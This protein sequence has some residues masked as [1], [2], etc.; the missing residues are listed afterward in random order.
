M[1][2]DNAPI[3]MTKG[4]EETV[5]YLR[6][7]A[8]AC[9]MVG[10]PLYEHLLD[11]AADDVERGGAVW[12]LLEPFVGRPLSYG[13]PLKL[14]GA[15]H[16][17]VLEGSAPQL[18]ELYPSAGGALDLDRSWPAFEQTLAEHADRLP[19]L[20]ERP[21]QTNEVGR[22]A[23]L[24]GGFLTVARETG[25]PLR[26][27]ELGT[28]AGLNLRW[29]RYLYSAGERRWGD[30]SS[31]VLQLLDPA[32]APLL[33]TDAVVGSRRGCDTHPLD[34]SS[35]EDRLTLMS[36]VW[37]DQTWRFSLLT[38]ALEEAAK[39]PALV[40]QADAADWIENALA[41]RVPNV[42]TI[43]FHSLVLFWM[44]RRERARITGA[45]S[46]AAAEAT[47]HSPFAWLKMEAAGEQADV[48]L[49][50]WPGGEQRTLARAGY[51]GRPVT[52][53]AGS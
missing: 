18:A 51:H 19:S 14:L 48:V 24:L 2:L 42:A 12:P 49:T 17:L 30:P 34:P 35:L 39:A 16:R 47:R 45:I 29:D 50:T 9:A 26:L 53:L 4:Q 27:L 5:R 13:A 32:S 1:S 23:A 22:S 3:S 20:I 44:G 15:V 31:N 46:A 37:P 28:S 41:E 11:A 21:V 43:V 10:S 38:A 6:G 7:Q 36:Y 40:E 52:W 25:L 8:D 33:D